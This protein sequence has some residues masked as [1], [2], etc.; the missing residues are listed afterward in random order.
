MLCY[1]YYILYK[2]V[3]KYLFKYNC[4]FLNTKVYLV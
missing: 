4:L 3:L 2:Y 1:G